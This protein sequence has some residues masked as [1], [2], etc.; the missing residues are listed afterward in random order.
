M[1]SKAKTGSA[2]LRAEA[3]QDAEERSRTTCGHSRIAKCFRARPRW[4]GW[5]IF[6]K[7]FLNGLVLRRMWCGCW[8]SLVRR[9]R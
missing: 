1:A 3:L 7:R 8:M 6:A 4:L 9:L 2:D 5:L